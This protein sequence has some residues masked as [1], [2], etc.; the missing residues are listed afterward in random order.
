M[1][2]EAEIRR[3]LTWVPRRDTTR[4]PKASKMAITSRPESLRRLGNC[5]L[6]LDGH[7]ND[8]SLREAEF[9]EVLTFKG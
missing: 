6:D 3:N 5:G 7:E 2:L 8:R 4:N 9:G 1:L